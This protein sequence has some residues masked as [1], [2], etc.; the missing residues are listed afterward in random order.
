[1]ISKLLLTIS[2]MHLVSGNMKIKSLFSQLI[3]HPSV[4]RWRFSPPDFQNSGGFESRLAGKKN[5]GGL[6][7][8]GGFLADLTNFAWVCCC[9]A[10]SGGF[11]GS[12][13]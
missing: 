7:I 11:E 3:P 10:D 4:A 12:I 1:M 9:L 2:N 6:S 5:S 13:S 8:S